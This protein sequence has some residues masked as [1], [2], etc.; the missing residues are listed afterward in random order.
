MIPKTASAAVDATGYVA[1]VNGSN[2]FVISADGTQVDYNLQPDTEY[3]WYYEDGSLVTYTRNGVT[4]NRDGMKTFAA[5]DAAFGE[6][7]GSLTL[8]FDYATSDLTNSDGYS[9]MNYPSINICITDGAGT[10]AIWSATSGGTGFTTETLTDRD[11]WAQLTLDCSAFADDSVYGKINECTDTSVLLNGKLNSTDVQWSDISDWTVA[12]FYTE[13]FA[14]TGDW[15]AWGENLWSDI[16]EAGDITPENEYGI[17]L[18]WGDTVGSMYGDYD[19]SY[20]GAA[21]ERSYG[22][23]VKAIDNVLVSAGNTDYA[24]CFTADTLPASDVPEPGSM[25][26]WA[27]GSMCGLFA[28]R[29]R[30]KQ[31]KDGRLEGKS[32]FNAI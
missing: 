31:P 28:V 12:G 7:I 3:N 5:T 8:Q 10:Y 14:P 2:E 21:A 32:R 6:T 20:V 16:S 13:Q 19:N 22:Y 18:I 1:T 30:R 4:A 17:A 11:G 26:V 15:G 29:R 24:I 9:Y 23:N 25:L 27:M